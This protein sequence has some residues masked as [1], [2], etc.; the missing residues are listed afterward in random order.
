M[1]VQSKDRRVQKMLERLMR[2][3]AFH[4][5]GITDPRARRGRRWTLAE[6]VN[7]AFLGM[8][9]ACPSL[10]DVENLTEELGPAG[11]KY[12]S[13]RVPDSTLWDLLSRLSA[14]ELREKNRDQVRSFWRS[15]RLEPVGL[16]CGVASID[17]KGLGALEHDADGDAQKGERSDGSPYWLSRVLRASLTSAASKPLLDQVCIGPKTNEVA[18]F[19]GFFDELQVVYKSL[20][21]IVTVDAGMTSKANADHVHAADKAYV[22]ALKEN[23]PELY[24]EAKRLLLPMAQAAPQAQT[25]WERH[26]GKLVQRRLYRTQEIAGYHGWDHLRQAWLVETWQRQ[27]HQA[28][29]TLVEQRFFL[30]NVTVG[31]LTAAQILIMIR[32]HWGIEN[33]C[34]WSLDLQW[35]EDSV[36]WC[37][38]GKA[39]EVLGLLRIMAY[40]VVQLARK[41]TLRIRTIDGAL[42]DPAPW[43]RL[44]EWVRQALRLDLEPHVTVSA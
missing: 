33:D 19:K 29:A 10:R 42:E 43:R 15:K 7:A 5:D 17:G 28:T 27:N 18:C 22:M 11:R 39:V 12:V 8:L 1:K 32:G 16:P 21:E 23:Q 24:A 26:K 35:K 41:R 34:F 36:P 30:T 6:L 40:N 3:P 25:D 13:R 44:F 37:S 38:T 2:S 20:F 9:A 31:R 4:W 14:P